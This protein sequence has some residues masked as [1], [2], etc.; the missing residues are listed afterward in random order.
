MKKYLILVNTDSGGS[1]TRL[2]E[3]ISYPKHSADIEFIIY[4]FEPIL[5]DKSTNRIIPKFFGSNNLL[6]FSLISFLFALREKSID[7]VVSWLVPNG[8]FV[9]LFARLTNLYRCVSIFR[10]QEL[11][12]IGARKGVFV[13]SIFRK[14]VRLQCVLSHKIQTQTL[15][16]KE[17]LLD[18]NICPSKIVVLGNNANSS[19]NIELLKQAKQVIVQPY[20]LYVG[21]ISI[22]TKGIDRIINYIKMYEFY[23]RKN[24]LSVVIVGK[25]PDKEY[26]LIEL[27]KLCIADLVLFTGDV[28]N[29]F[30]YYCYCEAVLIPSRTDSFPNVI[31][32]SILAKKP[33]LVSDLSNLRSVVDRQN[34]VDFDNVHEIHDRLIH[35]DNIAMNYA[36][37]YFNW[38][39]KFI[40]S[41]L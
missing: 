11:I 18:L 27:E 17:Q 34:R 33:F 40:S 14:M 39:E 6:W 3:L 21:Q 25:G 5:C 29:V 35:R 1:I 13:S 10:G 23:F 15:E 26:L 30:D 7:T 8:L 16:G 12:Q 4:S 38:S 24:N 19:R 37:L 20:F 32:E 9:M 2:R 31:V 28:V 36:N 22:N 41:L